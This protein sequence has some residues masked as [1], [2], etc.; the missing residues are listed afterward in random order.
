MPITTLDPR[1]ALIVIDLQEGVAR[2]ELAHP[3]ADVIAS[4]VKLLGAFRSHEL[5]VVIVTV[6]GVPSGRTDLS[7]ASGA[8]PSFP[9]GWADPI[10]ELDIQPSDI[11][12]VKHARSAFT[13]TGLDEKLHELGVTQ[14]VIV[15][16][17]T[18]SGVES[19]ARHGHE[20]GYSVT[21]PVDAM[22][23]ASPDAHQH[24]IATS[25]PR[26]AETGSTAEV[27]ALLEA[28]RA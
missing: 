12:V 24:S 23:D 10:A 17:A 8:A 16:I 14:L 1:T 19:T 22:T 20:Y 5:P 3:T 26:I 15:G 6:E 2:R 4:C 18:S 28:A 9:A 7:A 25:F 27:L 13:N 21:L 11:L